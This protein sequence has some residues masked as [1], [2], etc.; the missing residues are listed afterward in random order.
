M[1]KQKTP[2]IIKEFNI[3]REVFLGNKNLI[4]KEKQRER[5]RE[6]ELY[7]FDFCLIILI[8]TFSIFLF[9]HKN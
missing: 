7:F 1:A 8:G 2:E 6:R 9:Y 3:A 4:A 5:E